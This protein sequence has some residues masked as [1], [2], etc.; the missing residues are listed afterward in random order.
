MYVRPLLEYNAPIWSPH[1][2]CD[3]ASI[4]RVLRMGILT[5]RHNS[6]GYLVL[7]YKVVHRRSLY[8]RLMFHVTRCYV[9]ALVVTRAIFGTLILSR[10]RQFLV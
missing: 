7:L 1:L 5:L 4:E 2:K 8:L 3:I 10:V 6:E 9:I